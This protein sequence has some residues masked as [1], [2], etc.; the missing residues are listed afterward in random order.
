MKCKR[1]GK[2]RRLDAL[3]YCRDCIEDSLQ[4]YHSKL[5]VDGK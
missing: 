5:K 3:G 2:E 1:C 4:E